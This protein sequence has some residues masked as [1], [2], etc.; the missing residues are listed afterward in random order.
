MEKAISEPLAVNSKRSRRRDEA[1]S[2]FV[3]M[4]VLFVPALRYLCLHAGDLRVTLVGGF[5][6][7]LATIAAYGYVA[8]VLLFRIL[9]L[10]IHQSPLFLVCVALLGLHPVVTTTAIAYEIDQV[11]FRTNEAF[12]LA[13]VRK[14]GSPCFFNWGGSEFLNT[15]SKY[16]LVFDEAGRLTNG[17]PEA[18]SLLLGA[19]A[20]AY[21]R[22]SVHRLAEHFYSVEIAC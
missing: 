18:N 2:L 5:F 1:L 21:C 10:R 22:G 4:Y 3:L 19:D 15:R 20:A 6:A 9:T 17:S 14:T 16:F 11:R 7:L 12:Y 8:S 13:E